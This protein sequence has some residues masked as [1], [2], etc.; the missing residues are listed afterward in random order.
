M[1]VINGTEIANFTQS[2]ANDFNASAKHDESIETESHVPDVLIYK[3]NRF[4]D[5]IF[6]KINKILKQSYDPVSVRLSTN[7][8]TTKAPVKKQPT[9]KHTNNKT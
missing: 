9:K 2:L 6:G 8:K 7:T 3:Y 1:S 5:G 4:V